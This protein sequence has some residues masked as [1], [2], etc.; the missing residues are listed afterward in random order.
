MKEKHKK[1][2]RETPKEGKLNK[3]EEIQKEVKENEKE[4]KEA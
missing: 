3:K 4:M 1:R 2:E